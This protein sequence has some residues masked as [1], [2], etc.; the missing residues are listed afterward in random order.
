MSEMYVVQCNVVSALLRMSSSSF[1]SE[2][3]VL[4]CNVVSTLCMFD[5]CF[6]SDSPCFLCFYRAAWN[7][8]AV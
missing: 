3:Y 7:A 1:M 4:Q 2:M 5:L 6:L 8:D